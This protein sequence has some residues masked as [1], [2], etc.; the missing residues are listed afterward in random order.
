[1]EKSFLDKFI[2]DSIT[3]TKLIN[4]GKSKVEIID[5]LIKEKIN[6]GLVD[7]LYSGNYYFLTDELILLINYLS[8]FK[9]KSKLDEILLMIKLF[10][11]NSRVIESFIDSIKERYNSL[12]LK[13]N[14][15]IL[16]VVYHGFLSLYKWIV[17]NKEI[18][19]DSA[20]DES[21]VIASRYGNLDFVNYLIDN[22]A[23]ITYENYKALLQASKYGHADIVKCLLENRAD[24][25]S[26]NGEPLLLAVC[27][28]HLD[29]V[30]ELIRGGAN[31]YVSNN[32]IFKTARKKRNIEIINYLNLV[33]ELRKTDI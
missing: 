26:N 16:N 6:L 32:L 27:N 10:H 28:G 29:T 15:K 5:H 7:R 23:D 21:L 11:D 30:K 14:N 24:V 8:F 1:M 25:N 20:K 13:Y 4:N 33:H 3:L 18:Y 9:N 19:V 17:N 12:D 2:S 31:I 22:S